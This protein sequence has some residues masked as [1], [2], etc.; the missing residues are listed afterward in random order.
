MGGE[1][2]SE[3][4]E[5]KRLVREDPMAFIVSYT[6]LALKNEWGRAMNTAMYIAGKESAAKIA[7]QLPRADGLE[8]AASK[9]NSFFGNHWTLRLARKEGKTYAVFEK[10]MLRIMYAKAGIK[11]PEPLPFC[12]FHAGVVAGMLEVLTGM[13]VDIKPLSRGLENCLEEVVVGGG[14]GEG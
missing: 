10:C 3:V 9:I 2:K 1:V 11:G 8:D 14:N 13:R 6:A 7:E 4:E 12:Y 5:I